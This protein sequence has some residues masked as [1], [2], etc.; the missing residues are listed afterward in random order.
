MLAEFRSFLLRGNIVDLAVGLIAGAAFGGIVA[1]LVKDI[2]M[3]L[4][5][6]VVGKQDYTSLS[7]T[8]NDSI[9]SYGNFITVLITFV[10]TMAA[11]FFFIVKPVNL[12]TERLVTPAEGGESEQRECPE[13]LSEVP[14]KAT[15]CRFCTA[16]I[17]PATAS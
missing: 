5:T 4:V 9:V 7:F 3:P 16:A 8:I 10:L 17:T 12:M 14:S 6:A 13:C 1:S 2:I 15:R 11:I